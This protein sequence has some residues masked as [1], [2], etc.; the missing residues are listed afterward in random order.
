MDKI[1][2]KDLEVFAH[3]GVFPEENIL[4][5]KFLIDCELS[6][7]LRQAGISDDL[8]ESIDYGRICSDIS[9]I[10]TGEN[11]KLIEAA[12]EKIAAELLLRYPTVAEVRLE[13]KKPW[14]PVHMPVDMVSVEIVRSRHIAYLGIGSNIGDKEAYLDFA[15]DEL[16]HDPYTKVS[17]VSEFIITKPYGD[18]EQDDYLNGCLEI[19]TLHTPTEL[20]HLVNDIEERAGRKRVIHWGPRTLDIDILLY[21]ELVYDSET[22]HIPHKEMH[23]R[24]FV[25]DPLSTIAGTKRHPLIRKTIDE[26]RQELAC[27]QKQI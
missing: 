24:S 22:L 26:M 17:K 27:T 19:G 4:G 25:L 20:L 14:A 13:L 2:I 18:V 8:K 10:M 6:L 16:N 12:A 7:S 5:Q 15:I 3:H 9:D 23:K 11:Y 21:D 1:K